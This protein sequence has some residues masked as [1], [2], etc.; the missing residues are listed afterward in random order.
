[1][2]TSFHMDIFSDLSCYPVAEAIFFNNCVHMAS[3]FLLN[4]YN[5]GIR[6]AGAYSG[7]E[8]CG[9]FSR[10]WASCL[11]SGSSLATCCDCTAEPA[12]ISQS[13]RTCGLTTHLHSFIF[14]WWT[15]T[16]SSC[17]QGALHSATALGTSQTKRLRSPYWMDLSVENTHHSDR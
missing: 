17:H 1:M 9:V 7:Q 8:S 11:C 16:F 3:C 6:T 5:N 2:E 13:Y 12:G 4:F 14:F 10:W 15:K